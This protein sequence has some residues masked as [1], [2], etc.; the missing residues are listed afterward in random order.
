MR[1][2]R[3]DFVEGPDALAG[4]SASACEQQAARRPSGGM[5]SSWP[6]Q[7]GVRAA[8]LRFIRAVQPSY[9]ILRCGGCGVIA[10]PVAAAC[11]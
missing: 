9:V 7:R 6:L 8:L 1:V 4:D 2:F 3:Y 11:V 10:L 5:H